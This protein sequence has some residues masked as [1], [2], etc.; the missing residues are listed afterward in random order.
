MSLP[1][2]SVRVDDLMTKIICP[3]DRGQVLA[4]AKK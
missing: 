1:G 3:A 4:L 2:Y